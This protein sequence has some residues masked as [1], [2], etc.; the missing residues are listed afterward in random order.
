MTTIQI[1]GAPGS[2]KS[3]VAAIL[4][5]LLDMPLFAEPYEQNEFIPMVAQGLP[6]YF[7]C[8][9]RMIELT[10][11]QEAIAS[12]CQ[13]GAIID[14]GRL[15]RMGFIRHFFNEKAITKYQLLQL[16]QQMGQSVR[17]LNFPG[18]IFMLKASP[19]TLNKRVVDRGSEFESGYD[20]KYLRSLQD[21]IEVSSMFCGRIMINADR[22]V[23]EVVKSIHNEIRKGASNV[24]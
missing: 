5:Q 9:Q 21:S 6:F 19:S 24:R 7:E 22:D 8:E 3:T 18:Y 17:E 20:E 10:T 13:G 12:Y 16:R 14:G 2:G 15:Q 4:S 11:S 23:L 1:L